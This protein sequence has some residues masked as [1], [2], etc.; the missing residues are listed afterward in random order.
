MPVLAGGAESEAGIPKAPSDERRPGAMEELEHTCPQPRLTLTA[1]APF[2]DETSCQCRAPHEKLTIAQARLGTPVDRP[3]RVYADGI[4][5]LFHS[6]HA[7]ALMQAKT[8]FPNSYLLVGVCSDDL[9]HKFKGFTVMNETERYEAL[10]HCRYVDE[11]IRDAPWTLTPEFLEKHKID[12]VAHDDIPYSSAGS[13]D[14]YKHI[15]E[16]ATCRSAWSCRAFPAGFLFPLCSGMFVP[17]QRTEGI[18]TSDIITRIVRDYDVY[19]R[20]NLQ[21][22]YT[23]KEL[24]VSFINEKKYRF[25]NQVDKMKEKV[26]NVEEKSKEFVNKV[27]E[28]SHDLIQKWEEKSREFIGNFLELFG[29]DGALKQMFQE[30][31]GRML[32]AFS[33]RQSPTSSPTRGRS[34]SRS[35]SPPWVFNKA[36]PPSSPKAASAS[37]SSMSEGDEDEK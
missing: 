4:F 35:P 28:K 30:R 18:S 10:R 5:D 34:P 2:A 11:V 22:G 3:V 9:T 36:S 27:E 29:P 16:A 15:K 33:P 32:Q 24:N 31:S 7:R 37:L 20:R 26:K 21:R 13:D 23:A 14:V 25:Q 17:T 1:P 19:A 6:G 12:F 8:L